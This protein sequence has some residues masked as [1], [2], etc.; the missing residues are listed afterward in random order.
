M[1]KIGLIGGMGWESTAIYYATINKIMNEKKGGHHTANIIL[2]S[3]DF[4]QAYPL[5]KN[6]RHEEL[7]SLIEDSISTIHASNCSHALICCNTAHQVWPYL[8][9]KSKASLLHITD[10]VSEK[11]VALKLKKLGL[12]GTWSTLESTLYDERLK[13]AQIECI[14]PGKEDAQEIDRIIFEELMFG[15]INEASKSFVHQCINKMTREGADGVILGC[16]E[17]PMLVK[18][19][20]YS[21]AVLDSVHL[22]CLAA[23]RVA[24]GH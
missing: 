5:I 18:Q 9:E 11:A 15:N 8:S 24:L 19:H 16:T 22:H 17:L 13:A 20:E 7:A 14:K 6:K 21:I 23:I 3:I 10:S 1:K 12:L 4:G 2:S